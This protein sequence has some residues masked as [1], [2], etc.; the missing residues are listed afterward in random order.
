MQKI[1]GNQ[2]DSGIQGACPQYQVVAKVAGTCYIGCLMNR[3]DSLVFNQWM[4]FNQHT[5]HAINVDLM[6]D[7]GMVWC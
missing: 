3:Y 4:R 7:V 6:V 1:H 2:I 5:A